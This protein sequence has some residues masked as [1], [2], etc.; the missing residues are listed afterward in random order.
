MPE[1]PVE[2][3]GRDGARTKRAH[4]PCPHIL[5]YV[6]ENI[7]PRQIDLRV[8]MKCTNKN[9]VDLSQLLWSGWLEWQ[10]LVIKIQVST[11]LVFTKLIALEEL[12]MCNYC[13]HLS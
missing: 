3:A 1:R 7:A 4:F 2:D 13:C 6:F 5:M 12:D 9:A 11:A 8:S 10:I